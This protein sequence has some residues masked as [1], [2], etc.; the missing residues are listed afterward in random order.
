MS[1]R[2][3]PVEKDRNT[4][5]QMQASELRTT[6]PKSP[7]A[8][9]VSREGERSG[10]DRAKVYGYV[11]KQNFMLISI[12]L[13]SCCGCFNTITLICSLPAVLASIRVR[14]MSGDW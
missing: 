5:A 1:K 9:F 13:A 6:A 4:E 12:L 3:G 7:A 10:K 11:E 14:E 8:H 2:A